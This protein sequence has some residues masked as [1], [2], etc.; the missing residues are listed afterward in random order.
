MV[1]PVGLTNNQNT[2]VLPDLE[3]GFHKLDW[4]W[5]F[6]CARDS[7]VFVLDIALDIALDIYKDI[8]IDIAHD[9]IIDIAYDVAYEN[10]Q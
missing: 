1:G 5:H 4:Q 7:Y 8:V 2:L 3:L 10:A 9:I 6:R